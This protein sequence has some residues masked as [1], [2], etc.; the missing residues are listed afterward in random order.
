M[1]SP[2]FEAMFFGGMAQ[3]A[4]GSSSTQDQPIAVPDLQPSAF[5]DLLLYNS[6]HFYKQQRFGNGNDFLFYHNRYIYTET[7][8]I[9]SFDQACELCYAAKKYMVPRLVEDCSQFMWKDLVPENVCRALEFAN[10]YEDPTL[11][12]QCLDLIRKKTRQS[13]AASEFEEMTESTLLILVKEE[14]LSLGEAELFDAVKRWA[15]RQCAQREMESTGPNM[16]QVLTSVIAHIR[17]LTMTSEEFATSPAVSGVLTEAECLAVLMNLSSRDKW[18]MPPTL[19]T[20]R[21]QRQP[22]QNVLAAGP[23]SPVGH[24]MDGMIGPRCPSRSSPVSPYSAHTPSG[25]GGGQ[26]SLTS[27]GATGPR[28]YC[29]RRVEGESLVENS[30][31]LDCAVT[32]TVD[33]NVCIQGIVIS[34]QAQGRSADIGSAES[35]A[36]AAGSGG[37]YTEL[38]YCHLLDRDGTRL[39]YSHFSGRSPR[40]STLDVFF[41]RPVYVQRNREYR[42]CVV[43]NRQGSYP[44]GILNCSFH[45]NEF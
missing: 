29:Y 6:L 42:I 15:A 4:A 37:L 25:S 27:L 21:Q 30:G 1:G 20:C 18:P 16:R 43:L 39:T 5:R 7:H 34:S 38:L 13:L 22:R 19:S 45:L 41:N 2:V 14:V 40:R 17:F 26:S 23:S 8:S 24:N 11:K 32:L 3:A 36:A 10:L 44:L 28:I 31:I 33:R 12:A 9:S 35:A